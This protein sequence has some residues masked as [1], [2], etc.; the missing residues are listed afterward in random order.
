MDIWYFITMREHKAQKCS[1]TPN[2]AHKSMISGGITISS[3]YVV[4]AV[5]FI[6]EVVALD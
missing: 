2:F 1:K 4:S 6:I 5:L 3:G